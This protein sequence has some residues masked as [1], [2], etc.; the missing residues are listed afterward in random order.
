MNDLA[1]E[2]SQFLL[3]LA[4]GK[5]DAELAIADSA[6]AAIGAVEPWALVVKR[7]VDAFVALNK[8]TAPQTVVPDGRG[9]LVPSTNSR[10]GPDGSFLPSWHLAL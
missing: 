5:Y 4:H 10:A 8:T 1:Q 2:A 3:E 7:I 9:G 6:L